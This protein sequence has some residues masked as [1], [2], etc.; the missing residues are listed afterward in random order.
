VKSYCLFLF[1]TLA[2]CI[3]PGKSQ[4]IKGGSVGEAK[5]TA[6]TNVSW[7]SSEWSLTSDR[8]V[9]K[10]K[11]LLEIIDIVYPRSLTIVDETGLTDSRFDLL[12]EGTNAAPNEYWE[13][14][15]RT[16]R[17]NFLIVARV[18]K[19]QIEIYELTSGDEK[20]KALLE[21]A[22]EQRRDDRTT[23]NGWEFTGCTMDDLVAKLNGRLNLLDLPVYN[24]CKLKGRYNF[25]IDWEGT[26][27]P[28]KT[29]AALKKIGLNLEKVK[30][31]KEVL[32]VKG[33]KLQLP[34]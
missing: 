12:I 20:P 30:K 1:L 27:F 23:A 31:E 19:R 5:L 14:L 7:A 15:Q 25:T 18:E 6:S 4:E 22:A 9:V 29:A 8:F 3:D 24:E 28:D 32:V 10:N 2:A 34:K 33:T 11:T 16:L 13:S 26:L 21:S 17:K